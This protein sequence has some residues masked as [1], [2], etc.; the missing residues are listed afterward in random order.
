M[1]TTLNKSVR[2]YSDHV[3]YFKS[4]EYCDILVKKKFKQTTS[5][6]CKEKQKQNKF[7]IQIFSMI[8]TN[9]FHK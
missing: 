7:S 6:F 4:C 3:N 5:S 9:T 1:K 2:D 8:L